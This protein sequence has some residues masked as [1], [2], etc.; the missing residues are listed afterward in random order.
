MTNE[1]KPSDKPQAS[2]TGET[3]A[4]APKKEQ[5]TKQSHTGTSTA[6]VSETKHAAEETQRMAKGLCLA[7]KCREGAIQY[8]FCPKHFEAYQLGLMTKHGIPAK[9]YELKLRTLLRKNKV[10]AA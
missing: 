3:G 7:E 4:P 8:R 10:K 9:D 5:E 1:Q 2:A 6:S